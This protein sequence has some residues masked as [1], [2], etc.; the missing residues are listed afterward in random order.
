MLILHLESSAAQK[1]FLIA[2]LWVRGA[3]GFAEQEAPGGGWQLAGFF[4]NKIDT[5]DFA[6][7]NPRWEF[8]EDRD[9]VAVSQALWS[10]VLV[11]ER[12]Y[13]A[14]AWSTD[15]A[16]AGRLRIDMHAGQACGTGW[17]QATQLCLEAMERHLRP[18]TAVLD[19]GAGSGI[20]S[21]AAALLGASPVYACD[22]D[23]AAVAA[24]NARFLA[25]RV[26]AL[27]FTGSVRSVRDA[28]VDLVV[29]NINAETLVALAP[30]IVRVRKPG[31]RIILSGFPSRNAA[32]V[33]QAF[34]ASVETLEKDNWVALVC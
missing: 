7:Y 2:E 15:P 17:H 26:P 19:L 28:A 20:L 5:T 8:A 24:A 4:E 9:W 31:G 32:R 11:G 10:P 18:G 13:L 6:A 33:R 14:P 16:P 34:G 25:E 21:I 27:L 3:T 30:D 1:D 12:F 23:P 22:I 29:A